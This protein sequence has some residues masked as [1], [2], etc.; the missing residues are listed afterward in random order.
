MWKKY[1]R[2]KG[3][4]PGV[5]ARGSNRKFLTERQLAHGTRTA[6]EKSCKQDLDWCSAYKY[7]CTFSRK[8]HQRVRRRKLL[9]L[10]FLWQEKKRRL[11]QY[12]RNPGNLSFWRLTFWN[13][14]ILRSPLASL[15]KIVATFTTAPH[16]CRIDV[17]VI[18]PANIMFLEFWLPAF[19]RSK[20]SKVQ[21]SIQ[22]FILW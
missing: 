11:L 17:Q 20:L 5:K 22:Y 14:S 2:R 19:I 16:S 7:V 1:K 9:R 6:E 8:E 15:I 4:K 3:F 12:S 13:L 21:T 18:F 10:D